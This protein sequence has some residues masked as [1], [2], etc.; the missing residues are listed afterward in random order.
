MTLPRALTLPKTAALPRVLTVAGS[1]SGGGAGIQA[2]LKT[3][4]VLGTYGMSVV[5][6]VTAQNTLGVQG[7]HVL[8]PPFV[9]QQLHSVLSDIGADAVKTG[10]LGD[11]GVVRVVAEGLRRYAVRWVVVDPVLRS[12]SGHALLAEDAHRALVEN[13]FP[14]A[15]VVTPN[16]WEAAAL[17]GIDLTWAMGGDDERAAE[18]AVR[19]AARCIANMGPRYVI[20]KGGHLGAGRYRERAVDLVFDGRSFYTLEAERHPSRHTHGTGCTFAAAIAA[21]LARGVAVQEA[22]HLA[23]AFVTRAIGAAFP[24]GSG[25]GPVNHLA[26]NPSGPASDRGAATDRGAANPGG[27]DRPRRG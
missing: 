25:V 15:T 1:D 24:L 20:I 4:T 11:A 19:E 18:M 14:L 8:P 23:K 2:D 7:V 9:E 12:K 27:A 13:L 17:S 26:G 21:Y 6:A 10:M 5:T 22:L 3:F 16:A